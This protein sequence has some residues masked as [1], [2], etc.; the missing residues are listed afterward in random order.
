MFNT[1]LCDLIGIK[2]P[3]FQGGMAWISDAVLAS[4]VSNAGGLGI[5]AAGNSSAEYVSEQIKKAKALTNRPFG[6]NVMLLSHHADAVAEVIAQ[7]MVAVVT[8]GAGNPS[9]YMSRWLN[10][11]IK[12]IPVVPS[13]GL[14][15]L[16]QRNGAAAV[17]AEGYESG[18]HVGE[19]TTLA[20]VPQVC[21]AVDIPVVAAGGIGDGRGLAA[22]LMLGATGVQVGTRFL[23][24]KECNVHQNYKDK[25]IAARDIDTMTTGKKSGHPIRSLKTPFSREIFTKEYDPSA[26]DAELE[27]RSKGAYR[28]AALDGDL[29][30][31][32][33]L[34][35]QISGMISREQSAQEI[36]E[37]L[38]AEAEAILREAPKWL[39]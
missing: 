24:A 20:L 22:A 30:N 37:E 9:K 3:I 1:R 38:A 13:T 10:A 33:F 8:T 26:T 29:N 4:A 11:G 12:V 23:V 35:G 7:E 5:I 17:I 6:V 19:I 31:G 18:G 36:V 25:I 14:A 32:C 39:K 21:D 34:A 27:A 16:A 28:L 15:K 2:F